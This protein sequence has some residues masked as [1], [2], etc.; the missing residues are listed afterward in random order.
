MAY[1][2]DDE[3]VQIWQPSQEFPKSVRQAVLAGE[4]V[5]AHNAAFER[6]IWTY[7]L[8]SDHN[9]PVPK[10]EQFYCTAAQARSNCAPGS[11]EDVGRFAG[12]SMRKDH[13]GAALVRK[14]CIPPFKHTP[15]DLADLFNYCAQDV[16]AMRAI[17]KA[18]RP[19]SAEELADYWA[20]ERINDRGVLVDVDLAKAAQTYAVEELD[21]IQQEVR[22]VTDGEIT[23][24]RSP[25]MR[26]WVWGRVGP[27]ARR[28]MTVHKDGEEK[29][30]I[31]KTV[32]AALLILAEEN[33]DEVPPDAATVIQC[34]D[35]LWA[36]SVAKFVR[37]A[38]L[39]D[40]ED[41]RVRGAFVFAGGAAT[42]RACVSAATLVETETGAVPISALRLDE[43][44]LTHTGKFCKISRV[45]YKGRQIMYR[46]STVSGGWV[47]CTEQ[48]LLLTAEGWKSVKELVC[49]PRSGS[50]RGS[51]AAVYIA[52]VAYDGTSSSH[53]WADPRHGRC[54]RA[55]DSAART[56][57]DSE[58]R[59]LLQIQDGREEP[60]VWCEETSRCDSAFGLSVSVGRQARGIRAGASF[61]V[62]AG[63]WADDLAREMGDSP[64]RWR[65]VEQLARQLGDCDEGWASKVALSEIREVV[66]VGEKGVWDITVEGD[67]S[68]VAQGLIHHNSS[69]GLQVHNFARK[70]AKDPQAARHAM[71][72]G[73]QIVPAF[74][75]RVTDVL[76]GML[77]PA[78][79]PTAG[80]QFVVA[81][82][83]AIE[84]RVNPWLAATPAGDT[85]LEA[86][87]RGLDAY[88]VNAAATFNTS[89][90]AILAGY[91]AEDAVSTGQRQIGKVQELACGFGGGVGAFAAMGRVYNVNLP[92]HEA[93]RMVGAWRKANPWAPL[94]WS[95]LERAYMGAMRRKSQAVPAG[96]VSYLFDGAHL[97]YALPSGRILCYPHA[98]LD[99]DGIS[100][101]KASWKP[102]A[103]AKEWPRARLWPGLACENVTQAAAHDIL[104][105][106]LRELEREGEDVVLHVHDEIVCETSD[107]A[108]TTELM[109]RVMTNPPAWAA[110]L[111]LGIGIKTM[112]RYGK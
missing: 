36:S 8:W 70:V 102:A 89:Y 51:D 82:W 2:H 65:Q 38:A 109:K 67:A 44:V 16:R 101:A 27:E 66:C 76:K 18:L 93:K 104:R 64:H 1:A 15:Q 49:D 103:D 68:Y 110:G 46:L 105:H 106:A 88:I 84:G 81:D 62:D 83:S 99:S 40:V 22:E 92:E 80:K 17:S 96:R 47:E 56:T 53:D 74:G 61:S 111:P 75:K 50:P 55:G 13:K 12:A 4:R 85:K 43:K 3:E 90:D 21:A 10:L 87:R 19:L 39:A 72:R 25:R 24:V 32:R 57:E 35:D 60:H 52:A 48:H 42:G 41:H 86:F 28:L 73:H 37:M 79:I 5:Y 91:E 14:C 69:Y 94:F 45:I 11:L 59:E 97:W 6:L 63:A 7:V 95:D 30:S 78:L 98:R 107:P 58:S 9:A 29:Q 108:R 23:S 26:E 112:E 77:R 20:N 31:D 33:P 71:C 34:A 54:N 100:Y